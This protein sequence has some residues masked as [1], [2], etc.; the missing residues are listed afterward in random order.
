[1]SGKRRQVSKGQPPQQNWCGLPVVNKSPETLKPREKKE[2]RKRAPRNPRPVGGG[3]GSGK[4]GLKRGG[5]RRIL[6]EASQ[7]SHEKSHPR[8]SNHQKPSAQESVG[9][10]RRRLAGKT[11]ESIISLKKTGVSSFYGHRRERLAGRSRE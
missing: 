9:W 4:K 1:M 8:N 7:R 3:G 5:D 11:K 2:H 10:G 6:K